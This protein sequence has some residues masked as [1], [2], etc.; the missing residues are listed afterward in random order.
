MFKDTDEEDDALVV[1]G[2]A[3]K[4]Q[5]CTPENEIPIPAF[6]GVPLPPVNVMVA[7]FAPLAGLARH[8]IHIE[9][10]D[11]NHAVPDGTK[12]ICVNETPL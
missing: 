2:P 10:V 7:V 8:P 3:S 4:V 11:E 6:A 9:W 5:D 12:A 1:V